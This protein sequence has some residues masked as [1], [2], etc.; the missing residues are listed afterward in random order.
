MAQC[1]TAR[2]IGLDLASTAQASGTPRRTH[3]GG[4]IQ[5]YGFTLVELLVVIAIIGILV[6]LLLPAIQA[7]REAARRTECKNHLKQL[8]IAGH[9]FTDTHKVFSVGWLG[10]LVGRLSGSTDGRAPAGKLGLS[11]PWS[12]RGNIS[13]WSGTRVQMRRSEFAS[14]HWPNGR[15]S[16][17]CLL[18]PQPA[19]RPGVHNA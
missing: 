9:I 5:R 12:Y 2:R 19:S 3:C 6:A 18:L 1:L 16:R 17:P 15:N 14:S 10:R 8:G 11:A 13:G 4:L 7:A